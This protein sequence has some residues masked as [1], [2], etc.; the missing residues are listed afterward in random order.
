MTPRRWTATKTAGSRSV[1]PPVRAK[2]LGGLIVVVG[3]GL[4]A[5]ALAG[6]RGFASTQATITTRVGRFA[7]CVRRHGIT[8]LP[9]PKVIDGKV[10][11]ALPR[12]LTRKSPWLKRAQRAC[13]RLLPQAP[14]TQPGTGT[15]PK[16][17]RPGSG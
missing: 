9:N 1:Q 14:N 3:L 13:Q 15:G 16:T 7:A 17:T 6:P 8:N 10:V 4:L 11:L 5:A 2:Q 12:G